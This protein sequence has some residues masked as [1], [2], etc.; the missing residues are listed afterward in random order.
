MPSDHF[1]TFDEAAASTDAAC[2]CS[3]RAT[4]GTGECTPDITTLRE[5][6]GLAPIRQP[7]PEPAL[8]CSFC[9]LTSL[10]VD[11]LVASEQDP[12]CICN[13]CIGVAAA[14]VARELPSLHASKQP[15]PEPAPFTAPLDDG[16]LSF[17]DGPE[18]A[19][20]I[21]GRHPEVDSLDVY[22]RAQW[23]LGYDSAVA[24]AAPLRRELAATQATREA[25][26]LALVEIA[27]VDCLER[28]TIARRAL[29]TEHAPPAPIVHDFTGHRH[30]L[31]RDIEKLVDVHAVNELEAMRTFGQLLRDK[32]TVAEALATML[33]AEVTP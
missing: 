6:Y 24:A 10:Q 26:R 15:Q 30:N 20:K 31:T 25:Y 13:G 16:S 28:L 1:T 33:L 21:R 22:S 19:A 29:G 3:V 7:Q 2:T 5:A 18:E 4:V 8:H 23:E 11:M 12:A 27:S 17:V 14:L 32:R 9:R